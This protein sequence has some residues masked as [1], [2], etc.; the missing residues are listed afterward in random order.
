MFKGHKIIALIEKKQAEN[1]GLTQ[2]QISSQI[3]ISMVGL[4]NIWKGDQVPSVVMLE[5]IAN[6]FGVDMNYFFEDSEIKD[7]KTKEPKALILKEDQEVQYDCS[8]KTNP[9]ELLH[10]AQNKIIQLTEDCAEVKIENERL[11]NASAIASIATA[12]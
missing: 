9:W 12:G 1:K 6:Y 5:K 10:E 2:V 4:S 11:K 8:S 3:G 7:Y